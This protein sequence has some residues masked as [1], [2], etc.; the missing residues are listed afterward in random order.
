MAQLPPRLVRRRL[1]IQ[2]EDHLN[3]L[4]GLYRER[5]WSFGEV[6]RNPVDARPEAVD[7]WHTRD[8]DVVYA[9]HDNACRPTELT[10][11]WRNL[12]TIV[13]RDDNTPCLGW[14]HRFA[15]VL[16]PTY[17]SSMQMRL[18]N[19]TPTLHPRMLP[20][21]REAPACIFPNADLDG[22]LRELMWNL[23]FRP[24]M[25]RPPALF[26]EEDPGFRPA[27]MKWYT[28]Y[29]PQTVHDELTAAW[30]ARQRELAAATAD[31]SAPAPAPLAAPFRIIDPGD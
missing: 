29:G 19:L 11:E 5:G 10:V 2:L 16:P 18:V 28:A 20:P 22:T 26:A 15:V 7:G 6:V 9:T 13:A 14:T 31:E 4:A 12:P 23:L 3:W 1:A 25:V 21:D 27:E 17:P 30:D 24:D 8:F